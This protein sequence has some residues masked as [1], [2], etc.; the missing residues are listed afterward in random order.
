MENQE[1]K[2]TPLL[3]EVCDH[4]LKNQGY[5]NIH[6]YGK[7]ELLPYEETETRLRFKEGSEGYDESYLYENLYYTHLNSFKITKSNFL[8]FYFNTGDDGSQHDMRKQLG[9]EMVDQILKGDYN[10]NFDVQEAFDNCGYIRMSYCEGIDEGHPLEDCE[11]IDL[12][13][14]VNI[15]LID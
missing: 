10:H 15:V 3:V 6:Q 13:F 12:D 5:K 1:F 11:D 2:L 7:K 4:W 14:P 8:D 9:Y